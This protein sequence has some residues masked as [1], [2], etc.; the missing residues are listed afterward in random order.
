MTISS[1][2]SAMP[3]PMPPIPPPGKMNWRRRGNSGGSCSARI[4]A[5]RSAN[6]R[7][8]HARRVEVRR[9]RLGEHRL[10]GARR[11]EEEQAALALAAGALELLARLPQRDDPADLRL[12]LLLAADVLELDAPVGVARL[13]ALDLLDA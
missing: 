9:D 13:V 3:P 4:A 12:G 11:A 5:A 1:W 6:R 2:L 10:A 7:S 8:R